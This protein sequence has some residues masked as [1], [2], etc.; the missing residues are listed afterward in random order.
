LDFIHG[1]LLNGF[2]AGHTLSAKLS[3][4]VEN[5]FFMCGVSFDRGYEV[6]NQVVPAFELRVD[7]APCVPNVVPQGDQRIVR[8]DN[9]NDRQKEDDSDYYQ[10]WPHDYLP[11]NR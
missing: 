3:D 2:P 11:V 4:A 5:F 1:L 10:Y 6:G 7:V 9:V 8:Q